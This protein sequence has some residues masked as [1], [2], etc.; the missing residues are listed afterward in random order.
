MT[1][2][3]RRFSLEHAVKFVNASYDEEFSEFEPSESGSGSDESNSDYLD[4]SEEN[5]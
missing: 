3:S 1:S 4:V 5:L 2:R